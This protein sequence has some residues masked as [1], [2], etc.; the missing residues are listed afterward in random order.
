[1][2]ILIKDVYALLDGLALPEKAKSDARSVYAAI[3][4]A[5]GRVHGK[6]CD[7]VHFHE[8]GALDAVADV[9]GVCLAMEKLATDVALAEQMGRAGRLLVA[10][11]FDQQVLF[12][13]ILKDRQ[14]ILAGETE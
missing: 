10:E 14:R 7:L 4:E 11:R 5:E 3:A 13:H 12:G 8:V 6:R 9:A 1:M 2:R